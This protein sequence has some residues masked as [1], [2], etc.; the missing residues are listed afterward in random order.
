MQHRGHL[1]LL[2]EIILVP[3]PFLLELGFEEV[4]LP[5]RFFVDFFEDGD[6]FALFGYVR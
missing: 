3:A 1:L 5:A 6:D 4:D 2:A